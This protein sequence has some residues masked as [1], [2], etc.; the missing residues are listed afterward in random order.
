MVAM[1]TGDG[2]KIDPGAM[3]CAPM[4]GRRNHKL[5]VWENIM[6]REF[7]LSCSDFEQRVDTENFN[8]NDPWTPAPKD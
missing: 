6:G 5:T 2:F 3:T 7:D 4:Q 1:K 8:P